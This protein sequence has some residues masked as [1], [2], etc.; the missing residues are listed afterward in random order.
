MSPDFL[1]SY[2]SPILDHAAGLDAINADFAALAQFA[3]HRRFPTST[4]A[5]G[6]PWST[7]TRSI[8]QR[9]PEQSYAPAGQPPG[10]SRAARACYHYGFY[11]VIPGREPE[12]EGP[13]PGV[14]EAVQ[15]QGIKNGYTVYK[16]VMGADL[17]C[18]FVSGARSTPPTSRPEDA[19]T[20]AALRTGAP[21]P[22]RAADGARGVTRR[23]KR[24]RGPTCPFSR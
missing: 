22:R 19:E 21:G 11:Y 17:P 23:A 5:A 16:G 4:S 10:W 15:G 9:L 7:W 1:Y 12:V 14:P 18:Y 2:V 20:A 3:D 8:I 13:R 24:C 6:W